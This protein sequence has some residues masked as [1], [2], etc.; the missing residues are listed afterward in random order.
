MQIYRVNARRILNFGY[1]DGLLRDADILP[2]IAVTSDA[3]GMQY[4]LF[5]LRTPLSNSFIIA[6]TINAANFSFL[7]YSLL[8]T[9]ISGSCLCA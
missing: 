6:L 9:N 1:L 8:H 2:I 3:H 5:E 4:F 7:C